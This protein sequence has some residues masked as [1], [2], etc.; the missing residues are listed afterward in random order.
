MTIS[1]GRADA[2]LVLQPFASPAN[3]SAESSTTIRSRG[4]LSVVTPRSSRPI[5]DRTL[6]VRG[7]IPLG[8]TRK[9][10]GLAAMRGLFVF[11]GT[12]AF[13]D[14]PESCWDPQQI[15]GRLVLIE[16]GHATRG[17]LARARGYALAALVAPNSV[18]G[19]GRTAVSVD[20]GV[21][22]ICYVA[23]PMTDAKPT[24]HPIATPDV[25]PATLDRQ[26]LLARQR[27]NMRRALLKRRQRKSNQ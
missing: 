17:D 20:F 6:E 14:R 22:R 10:K 12:R 18:A 27:K 3:R 8:S 7:S 16:I 4:T 11:G 24:K 26:A 13:F 2:L 25:A 21:G 19:S 15:A 9:R 23:C 1:P 5:Q